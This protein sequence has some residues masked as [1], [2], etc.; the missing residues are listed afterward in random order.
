MIADDFRAS[1]GDRREDVRLWALKLF[2]RVGLVNHALMLAAAAVAFVDEAGDR[3]EQ[4]RRVEA[5]TAVIETA[6]SSPDGVDESTAADELI[7]SSRRY[8]DF[9]RGTT[10]ADG[11]ASAGAG[12]S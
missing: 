4:R 5:V 10:P 1:G 3:D 9:L 11:S 6:L 7:E 12:R 2:T 8:A